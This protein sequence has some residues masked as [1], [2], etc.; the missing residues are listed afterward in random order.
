MPETHAIRT[1]ARGG[2]GYPSGLLD[3]PDPPAALHVAGA[4]DPCAPAVAVVGARAATP[5]G[6]AQAGRLAGDLARLGFV[7]VSGLAHGIDAAAHR[8]AL[9]GGGATVAVMPGGL[10]V[11]TPVS[12]RDLARAIGARGALVSEQ[13]L[14]RDVRPG[15]FVRRNR[16]IAALARAV[17]VVE[18]GERSG[19]LSTASWASRLGR[20]LLAVPG[21]VDRAGSRGTH[22]LLRAG[23]ALCEGAADVVAALGG[24]ETSRDPAARLAAALDGEPRGVEALAEVAG[25]ALDQALEALLRLEWSGIAESLPGQRWRRRTGAVALAALA[26][27]ARVAAAR[28]PAGR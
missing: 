26:P 2:A 23:A 17:V 6:L 7:V 4:L 9:A 11:I 13:P 8:G 18:A 10:D 21:D 19:S 27:R 15:M 14:G 16:L 5:Y 3:L 22:A 24:H 12:H 28:P 1:L 20:A 25:V